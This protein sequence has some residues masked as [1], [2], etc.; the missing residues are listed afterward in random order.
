MTK[1]IQIKFE[2]EQLAYEKIFKALKKYGDYEI[3]GMLVGYK[4]EK[5]HF[6]ISDVTIANDISKFRI[7]KFIREPS[8]SIKMLI[9]SFKKKKHNYLGE[10][11]SHPSFSLYPSS[12]DVVTMQGILAD[13]G[14]GVNFVLLIIAKLNNEKADMAGFLFHKKLS[15]FIEADVNHVHCNKVNFEV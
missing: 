11:H 1:A 12:G 4:K 13:K 10:W 6:A 3:G 5:N 15:H 8:K 9:E 7:T 14:Y 2:L